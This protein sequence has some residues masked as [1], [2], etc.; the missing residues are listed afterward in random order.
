MCNNQY[1]TQLIGAH[2]KKTEK[3]MRLNKKNYLKIQM[4]KTT[5]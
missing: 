1:G 4:K 2:I 5:E 3:I